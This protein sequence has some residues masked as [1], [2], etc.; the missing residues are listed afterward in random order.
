M[1]TSKVL[2]GSLANWFW[3]W[4]SGNCTVSVQACTLLRSIILGM[5]WWCARKPEY[6]RLDQISRG[7]GSP[8][9]TETANFTQWDKQD[10]YRYNGHFNQNKSTNI[11]PTFDNLGTHRWLN[12]VIIARLGT[13][14][15]RRMTDKVPPA[16]GASRDWQIRGPVLTWTNFAMNKCWIDFTLLWW[17]V[18][19]VTRKSLSEK[20]AVNWFKFAT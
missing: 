1:A 6:L 16:V 2:T 20:E 4:R 11:I 5:Q 10:K 17:M 19:C 18:W 8:Q 14:K 15:R 3:N 9:S 13:W 7:E 12:L